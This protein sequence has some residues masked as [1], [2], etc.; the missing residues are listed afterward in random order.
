MKKIDFEKKRNNLINMDAGQFPLF[1]HLKNEM[2]MDE[3]MEPLRLEQ[4]VEMIEKIKELDEQGCSLIYALIRYYQI[5]E[6]KE[7]AVDVPFHMKKVKTGY[8]FCIEELPILLQ[9]LLFRFVDIHLKS[10][11]EQ[12]SFNKICVKE[13]SKKI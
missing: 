3:E 9:H 7:S 10:Q 13:E 4:K 12:Y 11:K 1:C 2:N 6:D 8:R 5:Y